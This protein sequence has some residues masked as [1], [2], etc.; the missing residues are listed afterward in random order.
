MA[1]ASEKPKSSSTRSARRRVTK[2]ASTEAK[3]ESSV[4]VANASAEV[5]TA[6]PVYDMMN[7]EVVE[8][9]WDAVAAELVLVLRDYTQH[10]YGLRA[11]QDLLPGVFG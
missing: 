1:K 11:T 6:A 7:F 9:T 4:A 5:G 10:Q 8:A 3:Q 2:S